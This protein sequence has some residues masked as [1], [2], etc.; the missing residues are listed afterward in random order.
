MLTDRV[1]DDVVRLAVL[2]EVFLRVV[3]HRVRSERSHQLEVLRVAHRGDVGAEVP[4]QLHPRGTDCPRRAVD[5]DPPARPEICLFQTSQRV[6]RSV[7]GWRSVLEADTG[8]HLRDSGALPHGDELR[9]R[10]EPEPGGAEDAV[11]DREL[12][13]RCSDCHDLSRQLAAEDRLPRPAKARDQATDEGD[14]KTAAPVC[15]TSVAV[16]P[17]DRRGVDL[18]EQFV[19]PGDGPLDVFEAQ[20]IR[21]YVL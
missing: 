6:E 5:E 2:G 8:W 14:G 4:G 19:L 13:D 10:T 20:N 15:F 12:T 7:A 3:D 17:V 1:E 16:Q 21:Q 18:D 11:A 9:M